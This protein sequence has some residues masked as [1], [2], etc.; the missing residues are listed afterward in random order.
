MY[1]HIT[2]TTTM[3]TLI[4]MLLRP[5]KTEVM[6]LDPPIWLIYHDFV[7]D[8]ENERLKELARP[9]VSL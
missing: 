1:M 3:E 9:K 5:I 4:C 6:F 8:E 7:S 2:I